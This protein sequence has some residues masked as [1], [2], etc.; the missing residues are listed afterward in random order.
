MPAVFRVAMKEKKKYF[1]LKT[2][3][4]S[5]AFALTG[6]RHTWK[7]QPNLRIQAAAGV[8]ALGAGVWLGVSAPGLA[9]IALAA[10][11]VI[12]AEIFN[13]SIE[14][15]LDMISPFR[16]PQAGRIKD[17]AAAAVLAAALGAFLT[18]L[19]I[20][21]PPLWARLSAL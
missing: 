18:G 19:F 9:V 4:R 17:M 16:S 15:I 13:S 10:F 7:T 11:A 5:F 12:S 21:G 6:L 1:F 2:R 14:A 8:L 20:L 3:L